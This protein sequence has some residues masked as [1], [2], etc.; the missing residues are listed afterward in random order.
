MKT[1]QFNKNNYHY[2]KISINKNS[3][4]SFKA[5]EFLILELMQKGYEQSEPETFR[6]KLENI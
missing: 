5:A 6:K 4:K 3:E 1:I 2:I